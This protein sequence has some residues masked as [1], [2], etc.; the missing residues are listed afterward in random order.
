MFGAHHDVERVLDQ[1][2]VVYASWLF[3]K[4][5]A[6]LGVTSATQQDG[7]IGRWPV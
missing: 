6:P 1:P 4:M 7:P 5:R 3:E 2:R